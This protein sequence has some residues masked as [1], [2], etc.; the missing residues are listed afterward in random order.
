MLPAADLALVELEVEDWVVEAVL[1]AEVL[2]VVEVEL[3]LVLLPLRLSSVGSVVKTAVS[4]VT[5]VQTLLIDPTP[6]TKLTAAH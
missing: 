3:V 2:A 1:V 4:P 6:A 5:L